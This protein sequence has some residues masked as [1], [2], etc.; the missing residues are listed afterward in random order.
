MGLNYLFSNRFRNYFFMSLVLSVAMLYGVFAMP[1]VTSNSPTVANYTTITNN[2][3]YIN[4]T[5]DENLSSSFVEWGNSSGFTN[6]TMSN[7]SLVNWYVNMTLLV[8]SV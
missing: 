5:S 7:T 3:T 1:L 6:V 4:I 2:W 8:D